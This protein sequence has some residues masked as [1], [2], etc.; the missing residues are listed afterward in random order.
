VTEQERLHRHRRHHNHKHPTA[1]V[2]LPKE[3]AKLGRPAQMEA[4]GRKK[5][6]PKAEHCDPAIDAAVAAIAVVQQ[7]KSANPG[8]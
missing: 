6:K 5:E 2:E 1:Q 4:L 7:A 3:P 8:T